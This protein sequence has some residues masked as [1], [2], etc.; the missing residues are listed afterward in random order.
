MSN[1]IALGVIG[2]PNVSTVSKKPSYLILLD[3][4]S[5]SPIKFIT[6]DRPA[7]INVGFLE[8]KGIFSD[9]SEEDIIKNFSTLLTNVEKDLILEMM[10]TQH[11]ILSIRSLVFKAK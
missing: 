2:V 11:R 1:D 10:F 5:K 6:L 4:K 8:A 9:E 7:F 3:N